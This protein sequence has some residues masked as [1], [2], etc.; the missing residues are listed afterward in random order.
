MSVS[1]LKVFECYLLESLN[2][3]ILFLFWNQQN[4][5]FRYKHYLLLLLLL[6]LTIQLNMILY[7]LKK[8]CFKK[9]NYKQFPLKI[10]KY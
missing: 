6:I 10:L 2:V 7:Y 9:I 1:E 5:I 3:R 4:V 8:K